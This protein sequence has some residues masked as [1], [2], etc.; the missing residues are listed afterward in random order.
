MF[1]LKSQVK[2]AFLSSD[3]IIDIKVLYCLYAV[4]S[5]IH[6]VSNNVNSILK[7]SRYK[8]QFIHIP[9]SVS[10]DNQVVNVQKIK[11]YCDH[12]GINFIAIGGIESIAFLHKYKD[13]F[14]N[15]IYFPTL[16]HKTLMMLDDKWKFAQILMNADI[17]TPKTMYIDDLEK[18]APANAKNIEQTVGYPLLVKPI[19]GDGGEGI[20]KVNDYEELYHHMTCG[21]RYSK[22]PLIIQ[23]YIDGFDIDLSFIAKEGKILSM[24]VQRWSEEDV[25]EFSRN[26]KIE[27]CG[28]N[29][30]NLFNYN[31][32]GH[33]DMR[34][35]HN[36]GKVYVIECNPRFWRS[37]TAAMWC[38][39]NFTEVTIQAAM[40]LDY[41]V[42]G[43]QGSYTL[44]GEKLRAIVKKPWSYFSLSKQDKKELLYI[45]S[46][47]LIHIVTYFR[48]RNRS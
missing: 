18:V 24:A 37:I 48:N 41:K 10:S 25:L 15:Q 9:W 7:Y 47:P 12:E 11:E 30:V 38:G 2:I 6:I 5:N 23:T 28:K 29:I 20:K 43:A 35:E 13:E 44:P 8:K 32:P 45:L 3:E 42:M 39:L 21:G 27:E 46:D 19:F 33:L 14:L 40:G 4:F 31:G 36:S 1:I 22:L 17:S 34:I 16:D 26:E